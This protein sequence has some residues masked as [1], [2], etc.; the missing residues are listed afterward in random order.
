M[1][2]RG[3]EVL[4]S[5]MDTVERDLL[6]PPDAD[7]CGNHQIRTESDMSAGIARMCLCPNSPGHE[8]Q[9]GCSSA[10]Q[11]PS[12]PTTREPVQGLFLSGEEPTK[13]DRDVLAALECADLD[14]GRYPAVHRWK[15]AI[16]C[17]SPSNRQS[18]PSPAIKGKLTT[19]LPD[20]GCPQSCSPG[21]GGP[22]A[23]SPRKPSPAP[24]SPGPGSPGRY[25]PANGG[26]LRRM[27]RLAQLAAL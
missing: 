22:S 12:V 19:Q 23:G 16:L 8:A 6:E 7:K 10:S 15:S 24:H 25:S 20:L 2:S 21:R 5:R 14:P 27:V 9:H 13:L 26:H 17:Y 18:W 1:K 11:E 4:R 3:E